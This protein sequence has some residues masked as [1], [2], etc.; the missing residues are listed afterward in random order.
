M[1]LEKITKDESAHD[2]ANQVSGTEFDEKWTE[3]LATHDFSLD[4]IRNEDLRGTITREM[5][6]LIESER[7]YQELHARA[8]DGNPEKCKADLERSESKDAA[9]LIEESKKRLMKFYGLKSHPDLV[10][11]IKKENEENKR[12]FDEFELEHWYLEETKAEG[13]ADLIEE[14]KK[15]LMKFYG[16]KSCAELV[17]K[18]NKENKQSFNESNW[19]D[20]HRIMSVKLLFPSPVPKDKDDVEQA[21]SK[22][23]LCLKR[24]EFA[25]VAVNRYFNKDYRDDFEVFIWY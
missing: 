3:I 20:W 4:D 12:E 25:D 24:L 23:Q 11:K 14:S 2:F 1:K 5:L 8:V 15:R 18:I 22:E 10:E 21:M 19:K 13:A 7:I 16:L 6:D 17:K 9:D